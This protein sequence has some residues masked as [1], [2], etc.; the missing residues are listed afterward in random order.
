MKLSLL[1]GSAHPALARTISQQLG[2]APTSDGLQRF[3][4]GEVH[5][6]IGE[7]VRGH[8]VYLV[9]PLGPPVNDTLIELLLLADACR[10]AGAARITA[11]APYV[12]YMRQDRRVSGRESVSARLIADLLGAATIQRLVAVDLHAQALEGFFPFPVEHLSAVPLLAE[13]VRPELP[14]NTVVVSPDLGG[15]RLAERYASMLGLPLAIL[16]KTRLSPYQVSVGGIVGEVRGRMPLI[17]DD[18]IS[19]GATV[20]AAYKALSL[21]DC[22]AGVA[23]VATHGLLSGAAADRLQA[24]GK[25]TLVLSDSLAVPADP[26]LP[27][28]RIGLGAL[29]ADAIARL[30]EDKSLAELLVHA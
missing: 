28:R 8:D 16:H 9:Q 21:A 25:P 3:P 23:V 6:E 10:R 18:M 20:E 15:V 24:L 17:V 22:S 2:V 26:T 1:S 29:L 19:T 30:H 14:K 7:S 27:M 11:I 12:G 13:A 4:D 5:V